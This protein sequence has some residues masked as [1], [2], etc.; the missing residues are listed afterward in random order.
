MMRLRSSVRCSKNVIVPPGS[1]ARPASCELGA[2]SV[3]GS[4][5]FLGVL[6]RFL[7]ICGSCSVFCGAFRA[8]RYGL[9]DGGNERSFACR[10]FCR[11]LVRES[12][13]TRRSRL[14]PRLTRL[15]S[16]GAGGY[17]FGSLF[18]LSQHS[19]T[20]E[21]AHLLFKRRFE[22]RGCFAE[23]GHELSQPTRKLRQLLW[24]ENNQDHDKNHDHVG[25]AQHF[26]TIAV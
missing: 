16:H 2:E 4:R 18:A 24:P 17:S 9:C 11:G 15:R 22:V 1:S 20:L 8:T 5:V 12:L 6:R 26:S 10:R 7:Q 13:G 19:L 21:V 23:F 25:N 14:S 3:T